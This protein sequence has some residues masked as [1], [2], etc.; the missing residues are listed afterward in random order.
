MAEKRAANGKRRK[1]YGKQH[2]DDDGETGDDDTILT[3]A[4]TSLMASLA[5]TICCL[6]ES[7]R[8]RLDSCILRVCVVSHTR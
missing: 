7:V 2:E 5:R 3:A 1:L 4:N 8:C 6:W